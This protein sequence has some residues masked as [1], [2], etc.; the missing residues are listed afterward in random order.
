MFFI[1]QLIYGGGGGVDKLFGKC[2]FWGLF[3]EAFLV[4]KL[5]ITD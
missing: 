2:P 5:L 1:K 3:G 4:G